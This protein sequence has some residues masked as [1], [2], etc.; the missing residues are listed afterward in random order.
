MIPQTRR[1]LVWLLLAILLAYITYLSF[2]AYLG[3]D[4]LIGY[5]NMFS[6]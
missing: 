3:P 5:A 6:C 2:R 1:P 4:F